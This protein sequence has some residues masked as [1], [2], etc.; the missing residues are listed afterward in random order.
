[1]EILLRVSVDDTV[2]AAALPFGDSDRQERQASQSSRNS[3]GGTHA[4]P[5]PLT[6][7][8]TPE[9]QLGG[10]ADQ[11]QNQAS[12][13]GPA[14]ETPTAKAYWSSHSSLLSLLVRVQCLAHT[15][16]AAGRLARRFRRFGVRG[17]RRRDRAVTVVQR[18]A[19][20]H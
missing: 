13:A 12:H 2:T 14:R 10:P 4:G 15:G 1:M 17:Q 20:Q 18:I 9:G 5:A 7:A 6:R 11:V 19:K 3:T 8:E 16:P